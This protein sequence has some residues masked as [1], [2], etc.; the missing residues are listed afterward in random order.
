MAAVTVG[1]REDDDNE[2][3]RRTPRRDLLDSGPRDRHFVGEVDDSPMGA[4]RLVLRFGDGRR[5]APPP[6]GA[7][8]AVSYRVGNRTAGNR[9]A[10]AVN[11]LVLGCGA[12]P[13]GGP[14][15]RNPLV[16]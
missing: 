9:G 14:R 1:W 7:T 11:P 16:A 15:V 4:G 3:P 10:E 8:L 2:S 13:H 6:P 12:E 5:G